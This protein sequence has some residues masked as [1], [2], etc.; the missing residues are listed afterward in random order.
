MN[1][2]TRLFIVA[3]AWTMLAPAHAASETK[4]VPVSVAQTFT[5][6]LEIKVEAPGELESQADPVIAAEAA[7]RVLEVFAREGSP[8]VVIDCWR[9]LDPEEVGGFATYRAL[10]IGY[11]TDNKQ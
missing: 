9:I 8:R 6:T 1:T 7:G 4:A 5:R 3:F 11:L 10:G 2:T